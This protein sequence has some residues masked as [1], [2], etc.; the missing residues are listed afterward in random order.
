MEP[1]YLAYV[2]I[3][4]GLLL[5]AAEFFIPSGGILFVLAICGL[6][7][8]VVMVFMYSSPATGWLTLIVLI[9]FVPVFTGVLFN[10]WKRSPIGKRIILSS[11]DEDTTF[12]SLPVIQELEQLRG[13]FGKAI[14]SLRPSGVVEFDGRRVDCISE[15]MMI[16]AGE[17]VRC[18][19][20]RAGRVVVRKVDKPDVSKLETE[21]FA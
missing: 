20:V 2:L 5:L 8:G 12:S 1:L 14:S 10:L 19:D 13:H 9:V 4:A 3:A 15:G 6:V 11:P 18:I 16:E 17:W 21:D 7:G